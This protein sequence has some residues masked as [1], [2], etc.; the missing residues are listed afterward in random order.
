MLPLPPKTTKWYTTAGK[1]YCLPA[2]VQ[3]YDIRLVRV[4]VWTYTPVTTSTWTFP[5][6]FE[7]SQIH[8][9]RL[10]MRS[11]CSPSGEI[12]TLIPGT[13]VLYMPWISSRIAFSPPLIARLFSSIFSSWRDQVCLPRRRSEEKTVRRDSNRGP[14]AALCVLYSCSNN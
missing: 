14:S 4:C 1:R 13:T 12:T 6:R 3:Q 7:R 11:C 2:A 10:R 9:H 8:S 5:A